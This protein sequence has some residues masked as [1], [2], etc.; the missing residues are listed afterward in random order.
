MYSQQPQTIRAHADMEIEYALEMGWMRE[1]SG[2]FYIRK[3]KTGL[4]LPRSPTCCDSLASVDC[5]AVCCA[6]KLVGITH[7]YKQT[8]YPKAELQFYQWNV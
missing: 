6:V 8:Y 5:L 2:Y 7:F 4:Q 1:C 3:Q